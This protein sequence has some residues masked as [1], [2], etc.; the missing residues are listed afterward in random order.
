MKKE[1]V[2]VKTV[3]AIFRESEKAMEADKDRKKETDEDLESTVRKTFLER[4]RTHI[5][6]E[7]GVHLS[8]DQVINYCLNH[9]LNSKYRKYK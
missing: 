6:S 1:T 7:I 4:A 5:F 9:T 2:E 8:E 3:E